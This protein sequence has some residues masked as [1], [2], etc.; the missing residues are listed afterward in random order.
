[1]KKIAVL[2]LFITAAVCLQAQTLSWD[3]KFLRGRAQESV[4]VSQ[5]IRMQTGDS[6]QF[7]LLPADN[8]FCYIV[9]YDSQREVKVLHDKPLT[10][11]V[12]T[13]FGQYALAEPSGMET[14]YI[15]MSLER[16]SNLES[17]IQNFNDNPGSRQHS[18]N[19]YREVVNLQNR[20]SRLGEPASSYIPSGGTT[21]SVLGAQ[22]HVT[23][24]SG[25]DLYVRAI[26]IR[27]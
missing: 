2:F 20:V 17:L 13:F 9:F 7:T 5:I 8:T 1:M 18:N 22:Q 23:R 15:I 25:S 21:R 11:G 26:T 4:P 10:G 12:E 27:H 3:V 16:Q 14:I 19:L 24:F 6:F